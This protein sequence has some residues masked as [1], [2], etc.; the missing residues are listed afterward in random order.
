[1]EKPLLL[2]RSIAISVC[3]L[4]FLLTSF[5]SEATHFYG[6]QLK[7]QQAGGNSIK[8]T[9]TSTWRRD[10][11]WPAPV[12]TNPIVG[13]VINTGSS[14]N[15]GSGAPGGIIPMNP[16]VVSVNLT[17]NTIN[18]IWEATYT[19]PTTGNFTTVWNLCCR[20]STLLNGNNDQ[21]TNFTTIVNVG[22]PFNNPPVSALP[23]VVYLSIGQPA[24]T[25]QIPANDPDGNNLTYRLS[26]TAESGLVTVAP[27]GLTIS[28]S[29]LVTF[30][31][32]GKLVTIPPQR[33][34]LQVMI[35]DGL[36]KTP[37]DM[38]I[39][40][41]GVSQPPVFVLPTPLPPNNNLIVSPGNLLSFTVAA[42]DPDGGQSVTLNP[43]A[44]PIG[45]THT[46]LLPVTGA[47]NGTV[48]STFNWTPTASQ[49]GNYVLS[50]VAVDNL[51]VQRI[52][53][54]NITVPCALS[55]SV[56][57]MPATCALNDG[58]ATTTVSNYSSLASLTYTWTGPNSFTAATAS[59]SNVPSGSY[60]LRVNDIATGCLTLTTVN[61]AGPASCVVLNCV[62]NTAVNTDL[63]NCSAV[64][65]GVDPI[66][67]PLNSA[68]NY[69]LTGATTGIGSGSVSGLTFEKGVTI[70][71]YTSVD[72]P[73]KTCTFS[74]TVNDN[75]VPVITCTPNIVVNNDPNACGA[76]VNYEGGS[77]SGHIFSSGTY[78]LTLR[79]FDISDPSVTITSVPITPSSGDYDNTT[80]M[81][82]DPTTGITY[83]IFN[84]YS[85][86]RPLATLDLQT[87]NAT[88]IGNTG[89]NIASIAFTSTGELY[90]INGNGN[91]SNANQL[92]R[93]DKTTGAVT[94]IMPVSFSGGHALAYNPDDDKMYHW[95]N[96][97]MESIDLN[98]NTITPIPCPTLEFENIMAATFNNAGGFYVSTLSTSFFEVLPDGNATILGF[99]DHFAKGLFRNG[100]SSGAG[101]TATD[102]CSAII[103]QTAG[104][105]SGSIFPIGITINTFVATDPSGNTATCSFTVT[106]TDNQIPVINT[107]GD[108]LVNTDAGVCG[109]SV[110]LIA[111]ATDNCT[112]GNPNGVRSDNQPLNSIFPVGATTVTWNVSDVNGN[113]AV[114]VIQT[115]IV[116]D[117]QAP[118]INTD[119]N[120]I[121][122]TDGGK[123][124]AM[125]ILNAS[126]SDNCPIGN[127][128]GLRSDAQ[129]LNAIYPIGSTTIIWNITDANGNNAIPV[130][131][132]ITVIDNEAPIISTN[133]NQIANT[134]PGVC[135]ATVE[136]SASTSD[137]CSVGNPVGVR[138]DSQP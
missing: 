123:C 74:I 75:E 78:D 137:N 72:E 40:M 91:G 61:I 118:V 125:V 93:I 113:A 3:L 14:F 133:G 2:I 71:T 109:A 29:G 28:S 124:G 59:I 18:T 43:F 4:F 68:V 33:F 77:N 5:S 135:G 131:Q 67:S 121:I 89:R 69:T 20:I 22:P 35:E 76:V 25:F 108:Q 105:P 38:T 119:G 32:V 120:Q 73:N 42:N 129:P 84:D 136:I 36:T 81:T 98:T 100:S 12:G 52:T 82:Q 30:N 106:V 31:T 39:E 44:T 19:Y 13:S 17:S 128:T 107:N 15:T 6:G 9:I 16:T 57:T 85:P 58:A 48:T 122:E 63:N 66:I 26:T 10:F 86:T 116:S 115:V 41:V 126:A 103:T 99:T 60:L 134:D 127:P 24:A 56:N 47:V 11:P 1:M 114:A 51:G 87:G 138:S 45:A 102:N 83:V 70:V 112:V 132:T 55:T 62:P 50:Y 23:D 79:E 80:G 65:T 8:F 46:P 96:G 92:L 88:I 104:L 7:W 34:G 21:P 97:I 110:I 54:I 49:V 90:G 64:V 130:T 94:N 95:T 37:V 53:S 117:N 111:S 101:I 27:A